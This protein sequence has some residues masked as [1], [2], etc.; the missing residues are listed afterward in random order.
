MNID[1]VVAIRTLLST[2]SVTAP[3]EFQ[4]GFD[5]YVAIHSPLSNSTQTTLNH[6]FRSICNDDQVRALFVD[7][8]EDHV[9]LD[10]ISPNGID[11]LVKYYT[12][13]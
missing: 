2:Q 5:A 10:H 3:H 1:L 13:L 6:Y 12:T 9:W 4:K 7:M 11:Y 8:T